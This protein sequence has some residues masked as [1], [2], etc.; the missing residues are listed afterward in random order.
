[1][2]PMQTYYIIYK[3]ETGFLAQMAAVIFGNVVIFISI[4]V[5]SPRDTSLVEQQWSLVIGEGYSIVDF[6]GEIYSQI[7]LHSQKCL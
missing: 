5:H 2:Y 4:I 7:Q 1:M 6:W 3:K